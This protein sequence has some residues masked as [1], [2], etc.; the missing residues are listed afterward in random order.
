MAVLADPAASAWLVYDYLAEEVFDRQDPAIQDFLL[1]TCILEKMNARL[2]DFLM[3]SSTSQATLL[4]LED[5]GLF[6]A[7]VDPCRQT[8]RY[9]QLFREF[10]R[11][12]LY[13]RES[14]PTI[15]SLHSKASQFYEREQ[16]WD[17]AVSHYLKAGEPVKAAHVVEAVG[18]R[19][20]FTGFSQTVERW[21][22]ALPEDL[23]SARPWLLA[24]RGRLSQLSV[25]HEESLRLLE[26]AY[27]LFQADGNREGQAWVTGEI[28][29]VMYRSG[30]LQ[31]AVPQFASALSLAK[32]D[33]VLRS[34]LLAAQAMAY[35][36][37]GMLQQS[38]DA[39]KASLQEL[40]GVEDRSR[41][42]WCESRAMRILAYGEMEMGLLQSAKRSGRRALDLCVTHELGEYEEGWVLG[43]LGAVLYA[44]GDLEDAISVLNRALSLSG[45]YI[46]DL[47][48]FT[49][50]WLGNSLRDTGQY[51]Q[52]EQAYAGSVGVAEL[53]RLHL[54]VLVGQAHE[55]RADAADLYRRYRES[56]RVVQRATAEVLFASM[57]REC[58]EARE[59]LEHVREGVRLLRAHGYR[60]RLASA[61]LHQARIESDLLELSESR[62]SLRQALELAAV[63]GYYHFFWWDP[64]LVADACRRA[65]E[66]DLFPEYVS[67]LAIRRLNSA[68]AAALAP[69][70]QDRRPEVR[71]RARDILAHLPERGAFSLRDG[72]LT[73]CSDPRIRASLLQALNDGVISS[74]GVQL[75]RARY[76]LSWREIEVFVEYY[77]RP[78]S[79]GGDTG[80]RLRKECA[81]RLSISDHTLR[82]HINNLRRKLAMP[83]WVSGET[84]INWAEQ[85][86]LLPQTEPVSSLELD[87]QR[88]RPAPP[89]TRAAR[90]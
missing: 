34:Q 9:H 37:A 2:C 47:Q 35:R 13:Q 73:E 3:S 5:Q 48:H 49:G 11:Q 87:S 68:S 59:A 80:T 72:T 46:R 36:E 83:A 25:R 10:L 29:Y 52:A 71:R 23:A 28:A 33:K 40:G 74:Q 58:R 19:Y 1:K 7:S 62:E 70:L 86:E 39:C 32:D 81:D 88:T 67:Q 77:L 90:F 15:C 41:R 69:L 55:V 24:L 26:R 60:P 8:F 38:V 6:T 30:R 45:R 22:E 43:H 51:A 53:E 18:E 4:A 50:L 85:Q 17:A 66:E 42:L 76:Q 75:L 27:R 89:R 65:L 12:K 64:A 16:E 44:C 31:Q 20:I 78:G 21:L 82:C 56:Q 61:L 54:K 63:D 57:L 14:H 79:G 84:V